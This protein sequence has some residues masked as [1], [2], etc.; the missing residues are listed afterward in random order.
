MAN[1]DPIR[2]RG[3]KASISA[4]RGALEPCWSTPEGGS[5]DP[6]LAERMRPLARKFFELCRKHGVTRVSEGGDMETAVR[7]FKRLFGVPEAGEF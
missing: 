2:A 7:R 4:Y 3:E 6:A 5:L 1:D